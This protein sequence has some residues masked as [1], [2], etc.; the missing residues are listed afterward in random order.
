MKVLAAVHGPGGAVPQQPGQAVP[1]R[2]D[3]LPALPRQRQGEGPAGGAVPH[4]CLPWCL[5]GHHTGPEGPQPQCS[6]PPQ[7]AECHLGHHA[8]PPQ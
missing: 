7:Q 2:C 3:G 4:H 5:P 8:G 6:Q 1:P